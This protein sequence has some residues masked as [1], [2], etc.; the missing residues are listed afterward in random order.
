MNPRVTTD[1]VVPEH[2]ICF[3]EIVADDP[4]AT[5]DFYAKAFG[6]RF[7]EATP[8]LGGAY[9]ADLP[10]GSIISIRGSMHEQETPVVRVYMRVMDIEAAT[11]QAEADGAMMALPPMEI[12]G[13]GRIAIYFLGGIQQGIWEL[14]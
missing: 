13:R 12:P 2:G 4:E 11:A 3:Y 10:E 7:S 9:Y 8:E 1:P 5:R 6:Y 14:P